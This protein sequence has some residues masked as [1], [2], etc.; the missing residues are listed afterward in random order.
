MIPFDTLA[1]DAKIWSY[2]ADR[3]LTDTEVAWVKEQLAEFLP[4]WAAHGTKLKAYGDVLNHAHVILAVDESVHN[5]SGCSIDSSV[6]FIK[7]LEQE[8]GVSFFNRMKMLA[9]NNGELFFVPFSD[10]NTLPENT[11]VFNNMISKVGEFRTN[12]KVRPNFFNS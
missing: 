8:L 9:E 11:T 1:D 5:A 12:W 2:Q 7:F 4:E 6:K 10:L 3:L